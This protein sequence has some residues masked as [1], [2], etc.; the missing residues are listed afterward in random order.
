[1]SRFDRYAERK[2]EPAPSRFDRYASGGGRNERPSAM[3]AFLSGAADTASFGFGDEAKGLIFGREEMERARQRQEEFRTYNPLA[4]GG[5]QLAG[6]FVGGGPATLGLRAALRGGSAM[7]GM[8]WGGRAAT[9]AGAGGAGTALFGAGTSQSEDIGSR[10]MTGAANFLPGAVTGGAFSLAGSTLSPIVSRMWN[11]ADPERAAADLLAR[12]LQREGLTEQALTQRLGE[13]AAMGRGGTVLDALG[14]SGEQ[15]AMGAANRPS[16]GRAMLRDMLEGRAQAI[17]PRA[18]QEIGDAFMGAGYGNAGDALRRLRDTQRQQAAPLYAQAW[19]ELGSVNP[20]RLRATVGETMRR[21]PE[22]FEPARDYARRLSLSETGREI[23]D[24]ADPRF[25]HYMTQGVQR[26]LGARLRA[27]F[28]GDIRG[29]QGAEIAAYSRAARQ[30]NDQV[31]RVLGPTYRRAQD[32]Y[33]GAASAQEA[34]ELGYD[35]FRPNLNTLQLENV[36]ERFARMRPGDK[37]HFRAAF[38][39]RLQ[40]LI[41][42]ADDTVGKTDVLRR[43]IGTSARRRLVQRVLGEGATSDLLRRFDYDRQLFQAGVNSGVRTNSHTAPILSA[44]AA[45]R[46]ATMTPATTG[47]GIVSRLFGPEL[48]RAA[49]VRNEQVSTALLR[50][51]AT[52]ADEALTGIQGARSVSEWGARRGLLSRAAELATKRAQDRQRATIASIAYGPYAGIGGETLFTH[53][54]VR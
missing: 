22:L 33:S 7:R 20:Q 4:F 8:G 45:Q 50:Q 23:A 13:H 54:G 11:G 5:G 48:R 6:A 1:M 18:Q 17:G 27:G 53:M 30:F 25:W 41:A 16:A 12:G 32:T 43:V 31:R 52:P 39:N 44:E 14:E 34:I 21:N 51:L 29:F 10:A 26:E 36:M 9:M 3:A 40:D 24:E 42:S 46:E 37:Q 19:R 15:L 35:A 38:A 49:D 28:M 47:G 2:S